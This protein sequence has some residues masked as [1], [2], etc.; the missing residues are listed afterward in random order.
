MHRQQNPLLTPCDYAFPSVT[1]PTFR[2]CQAN[3]QNGQMK[4]NNSKTHNAGN[5][6]IKGRIIT[7]YDN[8][9]MTNCDSCVIT[10]CALKY[11]QQL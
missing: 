4:N 9:F 2:S 7:N 1:S 8:I 3:K 6:E 5:L 11:L 10:E